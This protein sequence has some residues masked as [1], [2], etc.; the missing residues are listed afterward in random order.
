VPFSERLD[1]DEVIGNGGYGVVIN[2]NG[3]RQEISGGF[4]NT[5]NARMDII[6]I[7]EGL[8][9]INQPG[10]I[11]IY[12]TKWKA[13]GFNK[14]KYAVLWTKLDHILSLNQNNI[15]FKHS[16]DV[17]YSSDFQLAEQLGKSMSRK[18]NLPTDLQT[19]QNN[20]TDFFET[21]NK[22]MKFQ[23]TV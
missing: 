2:T 12:L 13:K 15:S 16:K 8:K 3:N 10:N 22:T 14:K 5:T 6:G 23:A 19:T 9:R 20:E 1:S 17:K 18:K 7:T 21:V 4:S 11:T